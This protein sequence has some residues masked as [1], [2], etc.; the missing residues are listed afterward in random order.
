MSPERHK[1]VPYSA[2]TSGLSP[3]PTLLLT[4]FEPYDRWT[5]NASWLALVELTRDL[6]VG[7]KVVTRRYPVDFSQARSRLAEDLAADYDFVLHLGQ[8]P[9]LARIHLEAIGINVAGHSSLLP[10]EFQPLVP[11]G[12]AAYRSTLPLA[13]WASEIRQLGIPCQVSYHAGTYLCNAVL[14]LAH[15]LACR[16]QLKTRT[17]FIHLPLAPSQVL[18]E[19]QDLPTMPSDLAAE[20]VR[21]IVRQLGERQLPETKAV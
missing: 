4:A 7:A 3:V 19:R 17:A 16:Q 18:A 11:E 21:H 10:D 14:Y 2:P 6:P 9:G 5:E 1:G 13:A 12:P 15:H 8:A 20:A